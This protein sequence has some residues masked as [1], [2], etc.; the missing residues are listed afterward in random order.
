MS[1]YTREIQDKAKG[2][3]QKIVHRAAKDGVIRGKEF[4]DLKRDSFFLGPVNSANSS[5]VA[6]AIAKEMR[7][8]PELRIGKGATEVTGVKQTK[9]GMLVHDPSKRPYEGLNIFGLHDDPGSNKW[10]ANSRGTYTYM[11]DLGSRG[12]REEES[13]GGGKQPGAA[14]EG[15]PAAPS[16]GLLDAAA[17]YDNGTGGGAGDLSVHYNPT[18]GGDMDTIVADI[19]KFG[20]DSTDSFANSVTDWRNLANLQAHEI[21]DSLNFHVGRFLGKPPKLGNPKK[22]YEYFSNKTFA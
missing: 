12:R 20:N 8:N 21:G 16:Q 3:A 17:V 14:P 4:D 1:S 9:G 18:P 11:G 6:S 22:L 13:D 10:V 5:Y 2:K 7:Q 15:D 19:A